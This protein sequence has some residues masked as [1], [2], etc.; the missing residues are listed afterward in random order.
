[1]HT[2]RKAVELGRDM[3][4]IPGRIIDEVA[5]GTNMLMREGKIFVSIEDFISKITSG[6]VQINMSFD[7]SVQDS[8]SQA[9]DLT[10]DAKRIYSLIQGKTGI[11]TDNLLSESGLDFINLQT[12][13]NELE[14]DGLITNAGGRY[15]AGI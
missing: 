1:M 3:W 14:F 9:S 2:A 15:S 7:D 10:D 4:S 13:L 12:V 11:T 5:K 6:R 8:S